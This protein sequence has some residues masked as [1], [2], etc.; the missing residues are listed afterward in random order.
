MLLKNLL[1]YYLECLRY[2][3]NYSIQLKQREFEASQIDPKE[4]SKVY[5]QYE[6]MGKQIK[7]EHSIMFGYPILR[8]GQGDKVSFLPLLLWNSS[9]FQLDRDFFKADQLGFHQELFKSISDK[10]SIFLSLYKL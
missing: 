3:S 7:N 9:T 4:I 1:Q 10:R 2:E 8:K 5:E 6:K